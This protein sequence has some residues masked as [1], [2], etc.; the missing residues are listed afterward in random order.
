MVEIMVP[1]ESVRSPNTKYTAQGLG[2]RVHLITLGW[3]LSHNLKDTVRLH[4]AQD[5]WSGKKRESFLEILELFPTRDIELIFHEYSAQDNQ[6]FRRYLLSMDITPQDFFYDDFPGWNELK[7]GINVSKY[8]YAIPLL[9]PPIESGVS[10]YIT[11]QWDSTGSQRNISEDAITEIVNAY[12]RD[13]YSV[14][15]VGGSALEP[16]YRDSL[17]SIAELISGAELHIGVDS[18][19]MHLAQLYLPP[20]R[21]HV[22][23]KLG[24]YWSHHLFRG[25]K[26][27]MILNAKGKKMSWFE[28]RYS[29]LRYNSPRLM[30]FKHAISSK[31]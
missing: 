6:D 15:T 29:A 3:V 10:S 28:L 5:H 31:R 17:S 21:I 13:G 25:L 26:N 16:K 30:K 8:L 19:F 20:E 14:I 18:G 24:R 22:Y 23:S 11:C 27:G 1:L 7:V 2:D 12:K 9:Q 4:L